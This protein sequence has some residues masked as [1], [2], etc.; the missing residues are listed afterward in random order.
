MFKRLLAALT[1]VALL[2][3]VAACSTADG[4][5]TTAR[6]KAGVA[7]PTQ[8]LERW[9]RDSQEVEAQLEALGY[10]V[11]LLYADDDVPL[12]VQQVGQ[13]IDEGVELLIIGAVDG[14]ALKDELARAKAAGIPV[15]AYDRLIRDSD[16]VDYYATFDNYQV[17]VLQGTHLLQEL[18]VLDSNGTPTNTADTFAIEIFAGSPDD[19]NA[20]VFYTAAMS[21]L[22]PYIDA[23]TLVV[24]SGETAFEAVATAAWDNN[25]AGE[26]MASLLSSNDT[27]LDAVLS[28]NDGI[29]R[30]VLEQSKSAGYGT[31]SQPLPVVT[32]QDAEVDSVKSLVAGEQ[33]STIYKDTRQLAEVAVLMG[34]YLLQ[35][36]QPEVNDTTSYDNGTKVVPSY[37]LPPRLV[38]VENYRESLIETGYL[39]EDELS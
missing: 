37:L 18:G 19:N 3:V 32:G 15:I 5:A 26:R 11:T 35:G 30:A 39:S 21:V 6:Q 16:A 28:P 14:S 22:Q 23:G 1:S 31:S 2:A 17:G 36:K 34:H 33:A 13:L 9:I 24:P 38:T 8:L 27:P 7:M 12:Q 20:T 25:T 29:A 4:A 10:D